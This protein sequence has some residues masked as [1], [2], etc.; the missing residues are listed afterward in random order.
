ME[1]KADLN[2]GDTAF[3]IAAIYGHLE[4]CKFLIES[5]ANL[6]ATGNNGWTALIWAGRYGYL[7]VCK[8]L[9]GIGANLKAISNC[10]TALMVA[11][12]YGQLEVCKF[13]IQSGANLESSLPIGPTTLMMAARHGQVEVC[14]FLVG[15][16]A[17]LEAVILDGIT[18]LRI[19]A[20]FDKP[21]VCEALI[22]HAFILS[23]GLTSEEYSSLDKKFLTGY[24]SLEKYFDNTGHKKQKDMI[25]N[26]LRGAT[27][28]RAQWYPIFMTLLIEGKAHKIPPKYYT[29][30]AEAV[31]QS[32][33]EKLKPLA[34]AALQKAQ[35]D[36]VRK[37]LNPDTLAERF[38][39][40]LRANILKRIK[41]KA[42]IDRANSE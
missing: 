34:E 1:K 4:V 30:A 36:K 23:D 35:S 5:G 18:P 3:L 12:G 27:D 2:D 25:H 29:L 11:A 22:T 6:E 16:G 7:E 13:L 20:L 8:F 37:I 39:P 32:T 15:I 21:E 38:G 19:A 41:Y 14:K 24:L 42:A 40:K 28:L 10:E 9:V 17:N 31:L 33:L 26:I